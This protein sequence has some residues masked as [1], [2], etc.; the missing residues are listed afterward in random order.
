M[1]NY[2]R[3]FHFLYEERFLDADKFVLEDEV[4]FE[5]A[6]GTQDVDRS[7]VLVI[8]LWSGA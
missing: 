8:L 6:A 3:C 1:T 2:T 5:G 4:V 7:V